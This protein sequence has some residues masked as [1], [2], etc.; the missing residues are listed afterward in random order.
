MTINAVSTSHIS[1][2]KAKPA[3]CDL[4]ERAS[5]GQTS[6]ITVHGKPKAQIGP[7]PATAT[8]AKALTEAWRKR[9]RNVRLNRPGQ[10]P[11]TLHQLIAEGRK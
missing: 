10:K 11:L 8:T 2:G 7:V 6:I 5:D 1:M 3:L 4:V 9:V